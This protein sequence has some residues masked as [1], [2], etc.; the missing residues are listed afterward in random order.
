M[1]AE[2]ADMTRTKRPGRR[3]QRRS[4]HQDLS[5]N[6]LLDAA[7]EVFGRRGFYE[8]TLKEVA[9]L[10][11]FSV[12][13][14]YSFFESKEDLY[15]NVFVRRGEEY[16]PAMAAV[17][18]EGGTPLE[19]LHRLLDFEVEYFRSFPNFARL[20][21]RAGRNGLPPSDSSLDEVLAENF[22]TAMVLQA[23]VISDGQAEG[24]LR[25]GDPEVLARL[26]SGLVAAF[27]SADPAVMDTGVGAG[28][29]LPLAALHEIV[30]RAFCS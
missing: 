7:E 16:I 18:E 27:Q 13:S 19:R 2:K 5:R 21:L 23:R 4:Q 14:V 24:S 25:A 3:E 17:V 12:G 8:T 15:L 28:K 1:M 26:F 20:Y 6:Q 29:G 9:D 11:E 10:A 22:R 30:E